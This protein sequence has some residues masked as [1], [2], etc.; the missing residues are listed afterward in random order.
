MSKTK[1][2]RPSLVES[3]TERLESLASPQF[4]S[5]TVLAGVVKLVQIALSNASLSPSVKIGMIETALDQAGLWDG[6]G[7]LR[8]RQVSADIV[9][10]EKKRAESMEKF[11]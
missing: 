7:T 8:L 11:D 1:G 5:Q 3:M 6:E 10:A 4:C 9:A 2:T